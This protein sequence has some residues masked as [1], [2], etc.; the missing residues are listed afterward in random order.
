MGYGDAGPNVWFGID[1]VIPTCQVQPLQPKVFENVFQ[2]NWLGTDDSAGVRSYDIQYMDSVRG[3][4]REWQVNQPP[5]KTYD[6][7]VGQPGHVYYFRCR[8]TDNAGNVGNYPDQPDTQTM[9]DPASR[10]PTPWW[11]EGYGF[12]RNLI[13]LN[14]MSDVDLPVGYTVQLSFDNSTI[15]TAADLYVSFTIGH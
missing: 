10:P 11:D 8:A 3:E 13:V 1:R 12:K 5:S 14:K 6:V 7:F 9:V 2:V 15:P 4:W